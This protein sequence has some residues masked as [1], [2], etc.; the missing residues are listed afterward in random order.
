MDQGT[1]PRTGRVTSPDLDDVR[2]FLR[3]EHVEVTDQAT[4][5]AAE[6]AS[7]GVVHDDPGARAQS[8]QILEILG[9][10]RLP[11][12]AVPQTWGG[13]KDGPQLRA[14]C[15]VRETLAA[16]S[17]LAD[18][19][20]ALQCLGSMPVTLGGSDELRR[21]VLPD[22]IAGELMAAFAMT[23][24][25]AGS[26]VASMRTR[27]TRD[28]ASWVLDGRKHLITNAGVADFYCVFAVTDPDAGA[29]GISCF[30]VESDTPGLEF[31]AAQ[32]LSEPHPLGALEFDRCRVPATHL[33]G[34]E[35]GGF[36]LGMMTLDRLRPTVAA[37]A[38]GMAARALDEALD[39]ATGRRQFGA[40]LAELQMTQQKL[41]R[42][43][44]ELTAAR[45]LTYRA[46]WCADRGQ[47]RITQEAAMAKSY[48]TEAAQRIV[49]DAVQVC[50]GRGCL[51]DHPVDRLY[52]A[53][54]AL[55]IYEGATEVQHLVI[56]RGLLKRWQRRQG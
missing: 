11:R 56:A 22:V 24:P 44:T 35:G 21:R 10:A 14:C 45:L 3:P 39:H 27:A 9:R 46:A 13:A 50:G 4:R 16:A 5:V 25:D 47:E 51:R 32:V 23:E 49:D 29:R 38:C 41:A 6:I 2:A 1:E 8:R 20:Y 7:L 33:L 40:P 26:D 42:M 52:R 17:P 30:F 28:G 18:S 15:L 37:A 34:E 53:V 31:T 43:S 54:R 48:A 19:V 55:R 36:R 12:H